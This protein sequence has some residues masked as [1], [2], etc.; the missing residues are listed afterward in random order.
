MVAVSLHK[1]AHLPV[2]ELGV[3]FCLAGMLHNTSP[4]S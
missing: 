3:A 4:L 1:H 2:I